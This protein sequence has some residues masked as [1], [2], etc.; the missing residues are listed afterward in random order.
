MYISL[1]KILFIYKYLLIL[2]ASF[3]L[4]LLDAND[5]PTQID[6]I[7]K[8]NSNN[9]LIYIRNKNINDEIL[10]NLIFQSDKRKSIAN[11]FKKINLFQDKKEKRNLNDIINSNKEQTEKINLFEQNLYFPNNDQY[12][13]FFCLIHQIH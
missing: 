13:F 8:T 10:N 12:D 2:V 3:E 11:E 4:K 1:L 9:S 7:L 6:N 5:N